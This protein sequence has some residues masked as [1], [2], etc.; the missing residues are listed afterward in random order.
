MEGEERNNVSTLDA[1]LNCKDKEAGDL[2]DGNLAV[3]AICIDRQS[4]FDAT[5]MLRRLECEPRSVLWNDGRE[6]TTSIDLSR[7]WR[8]QN[9][10][11]RLQ[12]AST[13]RTL[14]GGYFAAL[15]GN[16]TEPCELPLVAAAF[17]ACGCYQTM[18]ASHAT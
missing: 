3:D 4:G 6:P 17:G 18:V 12:A 7:N 9:C 10:F 5:A 16:G 14:D 11:W 15:Q 13:D 2:D 1:R 8:A